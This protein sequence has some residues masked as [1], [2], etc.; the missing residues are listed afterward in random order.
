MQLKQDTSCKINQQTGLFMTFGMQQAL[1]ALQLPVLELADWVKTEIENNP[2]LE[3]TGPASYNKPQLNIPYGHSSL[4]EHLMEQARLTFS[5]SEE[6]SLAELIIGNLDEKGFLQTNF[7]DLTGNF[8]LEKIQTFDP[9]GIA[10]LN[11]RHSLLLQLALLEKQKSL[12]YRII[13]EYYEDFLHNRI[14]ILQKALGC[15]LEEIENAIQK[16]IR[17][18]NLNPGA[19][20]R[21]TPTISICPD[22]YLQDQQIEVNEEP[23]P[24]FK[25]A[26]HEEN[27]FWHSY[28]QSAKW[29]VHILERRKKTLHSIGTLLIKKQRD[30]FTGEKNTPNPLT[31][32]EIARELN[33][34]ESTISRAIADKYISCSQGLLPLRDFFSHCAHSKN[35]PDGQELK[36]KLVDLIENENKER[37]LSDEALTGRL[38]KEGFSCARRTIAKYRQTLNI[39]HASLR[40]K[41]H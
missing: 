28:L 30:Y 26:S 24:A 27:A 8:V 23:I 33:L 3:F 35:S 15:T 4:F 17:S 14:P 32:G 18:L 36:A 21:D 12:A 39:P 10:A 38:R 19:P 11:H 29:L 34:H 41:F 16:D 31:I 6:L 9:P 7:E 37:P 20:F 40:R 5:S 2:L 1:H 22:L 13:D 25:I